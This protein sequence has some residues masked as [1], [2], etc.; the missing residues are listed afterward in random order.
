MSR[1]SRK[2]MRQLKRIRQSIWALKDFRNFSD[3]Y[4]MLPRE[5]RALIQRQVDQM[6]DIE[7]TLTIR[8]SLAN[9]REKDGTQKNK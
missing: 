9:R 8:Y 7:L 4:Q 6:E 5:E 3:V 1:Y 2:L